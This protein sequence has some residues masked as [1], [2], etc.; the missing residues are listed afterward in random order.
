M[1]DAYQRVLSACAGEHILLVTHAG[2]IRAIVAHTLQAGPAGMYR[3]RVDNAGISRIRHDHF[4]AKL[5]F[6]NGRL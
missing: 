6:H 5:E 3:I 4:G 1:T 2:V